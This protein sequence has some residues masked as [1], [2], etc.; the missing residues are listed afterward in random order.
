MLRRSEIAALHLAPADT[1]A[2]DLTGPASG[3]AIEIVT[4]ESVTAILA[5]SAHEPSG[6]AIHLT[7]CL[8]SPSRPGHAL[9]GAV[10]RRLPVG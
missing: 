9:H 1:T 6:K 2:A 5:A 10:K 4:H 3:H 8:V 7:A